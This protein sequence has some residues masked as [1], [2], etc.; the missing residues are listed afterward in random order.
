MMQY[1]P[2]DGVYVYFRYDDRQTVMCIM[3]TQDKPMTIDPKRFSE[4]IK[5]FKQGTEVTTDRVYNVEATLTIPQ[6]YVMVL[7]LK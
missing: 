6:K 5:N 1:V 3:N 7:E 4:C 2:E